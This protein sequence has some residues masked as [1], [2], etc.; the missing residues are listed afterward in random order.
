MRVRWRLIYERWLSFSCRL[1]SI[2]ALHPY[3]ELLLE[4]FFFL[5][6]FLLFFL[7]AFLEAGQ[8]FSENEK[9]GHKP[10]MQHT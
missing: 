5:E 1:V 8:R 3:V 2:V 4:K 9:K 10:A 7:E 6:A